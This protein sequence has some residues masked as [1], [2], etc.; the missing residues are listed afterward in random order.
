MFYRISGIVDSRGYGLGTWKSQAGKPVDVGVK[1][2]MDGDHQ[3]RRLKLLQEAAMIGQFS[4]PNVIKLIGLT[5]TKQK[6]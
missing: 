6:V 3:E 2:A 1:T 5:L 4:H